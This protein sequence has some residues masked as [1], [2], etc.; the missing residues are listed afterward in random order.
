MSDV[1][2]GELTLRLKGV[3]VSIGSSRLL[4][5]VSFGV[6]SQQITVLLGRNGVGKTTTLRT[7]LGMNRCEGSIEF[8]GEQI[9]NRRTHEI[10]RRG[11]SYVPENRDIFRTLTVAEN[12]R[13]AEHGG[14]ARR[15]LVA[16]LFPDLMG[17]LKQN[18]GSLS[19][20]QQQML[21]LS[22]A[23]LRE[24]KLLL[25]DEPTKGLAPKVVSE[26][27]AVLER[28][29]EHA[30]ILMVEQNLAVAQRLADHVAVMAEGVIAVEGPA[31][32]VLNRKNEL[33]GL[34]GVG[35]AERRDEKGTH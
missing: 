35:K 32:E 1:A 31:S 18:A 13:L 33:L 10:I 24:S 34:L 6:P 4:H 7:V 9:A 8:Q 19:G 16:E 28:M 27:V 30:T 3:R 17:R 5:D 14:G 2:R 15:E 12:L 23:L 11:I 26:V 21:A 20:G 22:R 25:I 29:R